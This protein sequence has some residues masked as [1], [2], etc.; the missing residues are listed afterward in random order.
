[1]VIYKSFYESRGRY[2]YISMILI[3]NNFTQFS[4]R[5]HFY[6]LNMRLQSVMVKNRKIWWWWWYT[7]FILSE[8]RGDYRWKVYPPW[9]EEKPYLTPR[10][11]NTFHLQESTGRP[12]DEL[13][14]VAI[15]TAYNLTQSIL[16][17]IIRKKQFHVWLLCILSRRSFFKFMTQNMN[18]S[19]WFI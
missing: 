19:Y 8:K 15:F 16:I 10:R 4:T 5:A 1:M 11:E 7:M 9:P 12:S 6:A 2:I 3:C 17:V 18:G 13:P 14:L